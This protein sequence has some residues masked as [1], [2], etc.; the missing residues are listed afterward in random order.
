MDAVENFV[1]AAHE[2]VAPK[3]KLQDAYGREVYTRSL[4]FNL[5]TM[6]ALRALGGFVKSVFGPS[7]PATEVCV[8][9]RPV[10]EQIAQVIAALYFRLESTRLRLDEVRRECNAELERRRREQ[11]HRRAVEGLWRDA[12]SNV[13][14]LTEAHFALCRRVGSLFTAIEHGDADHRAW[15]KEAI[16]AHF[17]GEPVSPPRKKKTKK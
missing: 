3:P 4:K 11:A 12:E 8:N 5:Q 16:F 6:G 10:N 2:A 13:R 1:G 9:G 14:Y 17:A 7:E 15:L